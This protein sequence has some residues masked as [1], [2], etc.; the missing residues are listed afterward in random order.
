M[1]PLSDVVTRPRT[2][3]Q[4]RQ[5]AHGKPASLPDPAG[6]RTLTQTLLGPE[7]LHAWQVCARCFLDICPALPRLCSQT[8]IQFPE[9][10]EEQPCSRLCGSRQLSTRVPL[11][12]DGEILCENRLDPPELDVERSQ[13]PPVRSLRAENVRPEAQGPA[14]FLVCPPKVPRATPGRLF[15]SSEPQ[16]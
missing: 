4:E 11:F 6:F 16:P 14:R 8:C 7:D 12:R 2:D 10:E 1:C 9:A 3:Q 5:A 13:D 15:N